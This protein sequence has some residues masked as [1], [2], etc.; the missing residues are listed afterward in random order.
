MTNRSSWSREF[1][2]EELCPSCKAAGAEQV[3]KELIINDEPGLS[4][5][6]VRCVKCGYCST[7]AS[8]IGLK[9]RMELLRVK[10]RMRERIALHM[11]IGAVLALAAIGAVTALAASLH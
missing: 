2:S 5:I 10:R 9:A 8:A 1:F 3:L 7:R 4:A 11:L 6:I